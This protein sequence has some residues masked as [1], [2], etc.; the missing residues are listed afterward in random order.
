M[1]KQDLE[2]FKENALSVES[3]VK[4]GIPVDL[5]YLKALQ[6]FI[7]QQKLITDE[8]TRFFNEKMQEERFTLEKDRVYSSQKLDI[9]K[10][11]EEK[12]MHDAELTFKEKEAN[13]AGKRYRLDR[14]KQKALLEIESAK[15]EIE[16]MRLEMER[17]S[18]KLTIEN[19]QSERKFKYASLAVTTIVG[20]LSIVVPLVVYRK[21]AYA[22]LKLIYK[23]EGRPTQDFKDAVR[24]IKGLTK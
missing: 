5:D 17:E 14:D 11:A 22:N 16:K 4:D 23:D 9:D 6:I 15:L 8:E 13:L 12:R 24:A 3:V 7:R 1:T 19:A 2:K 21:L 20:L 18:S 10:L